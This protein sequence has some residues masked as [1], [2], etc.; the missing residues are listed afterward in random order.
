[1]NKLVLLTTTALLTFGTFLPALAD[2]ATITQAAETNGLATQHQ[3]G[4]FAGVPTDNSATIVQV[5]GDGDVAT[6]EQDR[7][8]AL[9]GGFFDLAANSTETITQTSNA[10]ARASQEDNTNGPDVQTITQTGTTNF[11][12]S[13]QAISSPG[14][15]N[16]NQTS[17]QGQDSGSSVVQVMG[18]VIT[19]IAY[20]ANNTQSATQNGQANSR[21][22]QE[23]DGVATFNAETATQNASGANNTMASV[24]TNGNANTIVQTQDVGA[25]F[26]N[27]LAFVDS[28]NG[29][30][31]EQYQGMGS[32]SN[33][34]TTFVVGST[35]G[36]ALQYQANGVAGDSQFI[37][38][39]SDGVG[40][41]AGQG[42][43]TGGNVASIV[44]SGGS[45]DV[46]IQNQGLLSGNA[47][48]M[49]VNGGG[50][51]TH[52]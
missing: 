38:Q 26:D 19:N 28:A 5:N 42:Q 39:N 20:E 33:S 24:I 31:V 15:N 12:S 23:V 29:N 40:N 51:L 41:Q 43:G 18:S 48:F 3:P 21:I 10:N 16:N 4:Q 8:G 11:T 47:G 34:Q 25:T 50:V 35:N 17:T 32:S 27:Q 7:G 45:G 52:Q 13:L 14:G 30:Y 6:Q 9:P 44:Q 22:S 2:T 46:A 1:M 49:F 37:S 36:R